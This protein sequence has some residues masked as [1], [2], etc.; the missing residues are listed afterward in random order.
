MARTCLD[1]QHWRWEPGE[2]DWSDVTPGWAAEMCCVK[3]HWRLN[4]FADGRGDVRAYLKQAE[5]P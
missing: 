2:R 1:C 3:L 5:E 4:L